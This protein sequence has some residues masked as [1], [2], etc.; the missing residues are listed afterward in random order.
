MIEGMVAQLSDRLATQG[1]SPEEW[2]RLITAYGVLGDTEQATAI[3]T[4][5]QGVFGASDAAME[6]LRDAAARAGL[7]E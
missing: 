5:A 3:W 4:E 7:L 1:G 6:V 2:A